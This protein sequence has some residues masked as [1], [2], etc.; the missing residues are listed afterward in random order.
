[1]T[2]RK[3]IIII[4]IV[5]LAVLLIVISLS[6]WWQ[7]RVILPPAGNVN[8]AL[9]ARIPV[10]SDLTNSQAVKISVAKLEATLKAVA[11]TFAER[12]G[13]FSNKSNFENLNDLRDLMT[14]K[15]KG[16]TD[17]Y[18]SQQKTTFTADA[19]Y[20]GITSQALSATVT[21]FD[22]SVGRAEVEVNTQRQEA[23]GNTDNPRVFYQKILLKLAKT[24][25]GWKVDEPIWQ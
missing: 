20:Y 18:I 14:V 11:I 3:K 7:K 12:F 25:E 1:M 22:E 4:V 17:N 13:S 24:N 5:L 21:S 9:P 10:S 2:Q 19:A 8:A 6:W 16:W 23:K 15:M